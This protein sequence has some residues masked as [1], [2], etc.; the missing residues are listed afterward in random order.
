M[1]YVVMFS[2]GQ[3]GKYDFRKE[4]LYDKKNQTINTAE[5]MFIQ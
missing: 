4:I 5:L 2:L 1:I 3:S